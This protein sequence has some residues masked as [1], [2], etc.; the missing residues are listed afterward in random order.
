LGYKFVVE[1]IG[2]ELPDDGTNFS[3]PFAAPPLLADLNAP[4]A[5]ALAQSLLATDSDLNSK[6]GL[7]NGAFD[8]SGMSLLDPS[9]ENDWFIPYQQGGSY[10]GAF[11]LDA[12]YGV[13]EEATWDD[14]GDLSSSLND[15]LGQYQGIEGGF[16]PNDNP[17]DGQVPEASSLAMAAI[18][19]VLCGLKRRR[20]P[21]TLQS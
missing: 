18:G 16:H 21:G 4:A 5:L 13:L 14:L 1:P 6:Y 7:S 15:L 3:D 20:P 2:P 8:S 12:H 19:T 10:T 17:I 11:L 9:G